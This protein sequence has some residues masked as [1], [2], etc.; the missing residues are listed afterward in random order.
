MPGDSPV[1]FIVI[2]IFQ[3][4]RQA[5]VF[6]CRILEAVTQDIFYA[7]RNLEIGQACAFP[8]SVALKI[9]NM[10]HLFEYDT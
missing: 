7:F 8:E 4:F 10:C 6:E 3:M 1:V 2:I 5:E 9:I